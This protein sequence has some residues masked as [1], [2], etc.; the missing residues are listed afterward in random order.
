MQTIISCQKQTLSQK[1]A[2]NF[3]QTLR[4]RLQ[5]ILQESLLSQFQ[6]HTLPDN[7][8]LAR[9]RQVNNCRPSSVCLYPLPVED[10]RTVGPEVDE[11]IDTERA[12]PPADVGTCQGNCTSMAP[13]H[14][15]HEL[16]VWNAHP[17]RRSCMH[18][19]THPLHSV[20]HSCSS[21]HS[22]MLLSLKPVV[23]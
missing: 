3:A 1:A 9:S 15:S 8:E 19:L 11:V 6:S 22:F 5:S 18:S 23:L 2:S 12:G 13:T 20:M 7:F 10:R 14:C 4:L 17:C 16:M 21:I